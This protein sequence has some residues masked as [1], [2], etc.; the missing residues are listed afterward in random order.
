M[1][2]PM[3]P[4]ETVAV[5]DRHRAVEH[6]AVSSASATSTVRATFAARGLH[7]FQD[8]KVGRDATAHV[9]SMSN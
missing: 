4:M 1:T 8:R 3:Q 2:I 5:R 7:E 9:A 6:V